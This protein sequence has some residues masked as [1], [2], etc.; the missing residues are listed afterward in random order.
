MH[1]WQRFVRETSQ[2]F[3]RTTKVFAKLNQSFHELLWLLALI[4]ALQVVTYM[5]HIYMYMYIEAR[6]LKIHPRSVT[7]P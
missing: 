7:F 4:T 5:A 1:Y 6:I 3:N 2:R